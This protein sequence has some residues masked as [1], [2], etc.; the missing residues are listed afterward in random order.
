MESGWCLNTWMYSL[1]N[2]NFCCKNVPLKPERCPDTNFYFTDNTRFCH[3]NNLQCHQSQQSCIMTTG[4]WFNIKMSAHQYRKSHCGDKTVVRSS[5]LHNGISYIGK[6]TSLYWIRSLVVFRGSST[7]ILSL[8]SSYRKY[9]LYIEVG[10]SGLPQ[11]K[12]V[13]CKYQNSHYRIRLHGGCLI[14][15]MEIPYP[16]SQSLYWDG[17]QG[18]DSI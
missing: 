16:G 15:I 18:P 2:M 9:C 10:P 3:D 1:Q 11:Y 14:F 6:M 17:A 12:D 4:S 7:I 13:S 8:W 5:Y